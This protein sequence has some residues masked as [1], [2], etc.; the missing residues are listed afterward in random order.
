MK[1]A[2]TAVF[3][4]F[5]LT[6]AVLGADHVANAPPANLHPPTPALPLPPLDKLPIVAK[7]DPFV[8]L[9][10]TPVKTKEDWPARRK[11]LVQLGFGLKSFAHPRW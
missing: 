11:E 9:D 7:V 6:T 5:A 3:A 2:F 8:Y 10:G 1:H 4:I